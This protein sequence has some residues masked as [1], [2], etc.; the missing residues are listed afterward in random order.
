MVVTRGPVVRIRNLA[1]QFGNLATIRSI[2]FSIRGNSVANVVNPG[3]TNGSAAF[4]VVYNCCPPARNGVFCGNRSVAG[5][6][7]C[8][9]AGV[10]VTHAFRVVGP[11][12]GLDILSGIATT[13]CFNRTNTGDRGRTGRH[14]VRILRFANLCR[15]HR[16]VSGSVNAPSRG[17]LRVTHT[18][19]AG[20]RIL[21]LSRGVTNLGPTRARRTVR[22]VHGVGR[23]NIAVLLV[24]RVVGTIIDLYRGIVI[25]R[26]NRGVTRNAPRRIVGSPCIVRICLNAGGRNTDTW[27]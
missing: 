23:S 3:N 6:G 26:R 21:F 8:R 15:G 12:G 14:T 25:L 19:T 22:L 4:G 27:D 24:R 11:L 9:C 20:P 17:H 2:S 7:T 18:L 5:G 16:I 1:G 13:T 10:G